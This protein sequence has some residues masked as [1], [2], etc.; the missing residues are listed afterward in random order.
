[1]KSMKT[2]RM[3]SNS[4]PVTLIFGQEGRG[5][6]TLASR[7]PRPLFFAYERGIPANIEVDAVQNI[8]SFGATMDVLRHIYTE[9]APNHD[10]LV[11]DTADALE[12]HVIE[13]LCT[14]QGWDNIEKP[15][16]G[17]GWVMA[18]DLWRQFIRSITAIRDKHSKIILLIAHTTI[19]RIDDPRAPTFTSYQPKL[20]KRARALLMDACDIVAFLA[21]DLRVITDDGGFRE[22]TRAT[23]SNGRYLFVEGR[24]SFAAKNR[25][26]M[27]EK[28]AIP[29]DFNFSEL[30]KFW[31]GK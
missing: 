31:S 23:A 6:T 22:R 9:G 4:V 20:H 17:K 11:F 13:H 8:D 5:K 16:Y 2:E 19:E 3:R 30:S 7:F 18:D 29:M 14:R 27:P 24:P 21:E 26:A 10:T 12:A 25:F 28:I 15:P 1:M